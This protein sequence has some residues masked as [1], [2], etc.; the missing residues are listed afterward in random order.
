MFTYREIKDSLIFFFLF[1][2]F[3]LMKFLISI[4]FAKIILIKFP[5]AFC[6]FQLLIP[7][8][9]NS[10]HLA[11]VIPQSPGFS[12]VSE[13]TFQPTGLFLDLSVCNQND[14]ILLRG[15]ILGSSFSYITLSPWVIM[16]SPITWI[17]LLFENV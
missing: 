13:R 17:W 2:G 16:S 6:C 14:N 8:F 12:L 9:T 15:S 3:H 4:I 1:S 11:C 5:D 10:L 7:S